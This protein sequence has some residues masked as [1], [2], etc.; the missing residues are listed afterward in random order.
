VTIKDQM[1]NTATNIRNLQ[2]TELILRLQ[3]QEMVAGFGMFALRTSGLDEVLVE[4]CRVA[5]AGLQTEFSKVLQFRPA[6]GDFLVVAGCGWR[7]GV[8]G[9]AILGAG[10][11]S[12]AG[13]AL[14]TDQPVISN[15]LGEEDRFRTP[16]LLV[17]HGVHSAINVAIEA[18][19]AAVPFGVL[20]VDGTSRSDFVAADT[21]FL[22]SL[23]NVLVATLV[24]NEAER[25]KDALLR[26]KDLLMQEVH[27]RVK[28]SLHLVR[29]LLQLQARGANDETQEQLEAAAGRIMTIAVVHQRLY[30]GGSVTHTDAAVYLRALASD[31]QSMMADDPANVR[32]IV[33]QAESLPLAAD[34]ITPLGLITCELVT[35]ALK[36][37]TGRVLVIFRQVPEGLQVRVE[38][39]GPGFPPGFEARLS[40]GLGMRLVVALAKGNPAEAVV[41]DPSVLHGCVVATLRP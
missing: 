4:A 18:P 8:V 9:H 19:D 38:D 26:E 31:M 1:P 6:S 16:D 3:Q 21:A 39:E 33:V 24:R 10:L 23:S 34:R 37:G 36:H 22:Q 20:E 41:I 7:A 17:E 5:S 12:P 15:N 2:P 29:T 11:D 27:H 32:D 30:E 25:A 40:D 28:N 14:Q 35:N 13:Y